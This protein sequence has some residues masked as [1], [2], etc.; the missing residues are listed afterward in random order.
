M[1]LRDRFGGSPLP[2]CGSQGVTL[3]LFASVSSSVHGD[4]NTTLYSSCDKLVTQCLAHSRCQIISI[5]FQKAHHL[6]MSGPVYSLN[7]LLVTLLSCD[8]CHFWKSLGLKPSSVHVFWL[9][10]MISVFLSNFSDTLWPSHCLLQTLK[11]GLGF[12]C[13]TNIFGAP[14]MCQH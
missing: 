10:Q 9:S 13:L 1:T 2:N 12:I 5:L 6:L 11:N 8:R 14:T 4:S 3:L 7:I